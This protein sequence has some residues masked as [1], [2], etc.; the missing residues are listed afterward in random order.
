M[1]A[2]WWPSTAGLFLH[3]AAAPVMLLNLRP[4][5]ELFGWLF[6]LLVSFSGALAVNRSPARSPCKRQIGIGFCPPSPPC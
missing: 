3:I 5:P 2:A 6:I 4:G 1:K